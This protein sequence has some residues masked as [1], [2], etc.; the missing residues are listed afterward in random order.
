MS[1][2]IET[3]FLKSKK[4]GEVGEIFDRSSCFMAKAPQCFTLG[5]IYEAHQ[6][7]IQEDLLNFIDSGKLDAALWTKTLYCRRPRR[8]HQNYNTRGFLYL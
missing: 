1:P 5:D 6:K 7:A 3:I 4:Q 8:K 2:A